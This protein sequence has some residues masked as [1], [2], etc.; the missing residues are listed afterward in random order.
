MLKSR[1]QD[2]GGRDNVIVGRILSWDCVENVLWGFTNT[3]E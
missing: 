2:G 3:F 1:I